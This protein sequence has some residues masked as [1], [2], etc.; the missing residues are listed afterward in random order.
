MN[1]PRIIFSFVFLVL[2][3]TQS[4]GVNCVID[5]A[6]WPIPAEEIS[7]EDVLV[8][9]NDNSPDS[10]E[11]GKYYAEKRNLGPDSIVRLATRPT[12]GLVFLE[13]R[14]M[15]NQIIKYMQEN[16]LEVGAPAAPLCEDGNA[17]YDL[18][19][20]GPYYCEAS[21]DHLRRYT[22]IRYLVTTRGVPY[23][24]KIN[25][26]PFGD[27]YTSVDNY[28]AYWLVRYFSQDVKLNFTER[29]RVFADGRGMR[30][31]DTAHD[32]ELI[33]GRIDAVEDG[34]IDVAG[35]K[36][37]A[38]KAL[39]DRIIDAENNGIYGKL[40][41]S[42][43]D[44]TAPPASWL[45]YS[46]G[47]AD[48]YGNTDSAKGDVTS[49]QYQLGI[50]G[51]NQPECTDVDYLLTDG[52][53]PQYCNVRFTN[54]GKNSAPGKSTSQVE[55]ADDALIYLGSMHE[56]A[57][58]GGSFNALLNWVKD[59]TCNA[60]LCEDFLDEVYHDACVASSTDV[61]KEINTDCVGVAE[62]F[63]GYNFRSYPVASMDLWPTGYRGT[64]EGGDLV[65]P[66]VRNESGIGHTDDY[67]LWLRNADTVGAK[68]Y[69]NI[70]Y[71][72]N[73]EATNNCRGSSDINMVTWVNFDSPYPVV[74][75]TNPQQYR[76]SFWYKSIDVN[77]GTE[78]AVQLKVL[79]SDGDG[80]DEDDWVDYG[81]ETLTE[82][83]QPANSEVI[84]NNN[85]TQIE[86]SFPL[87]SKSHKLKKLEFKIRTASY[88]DD[89]GVY[90]G[91][92]YDGEIAFDDFSIRELTDAPD[93]ELAKNPSFT[94]GHKE[95]SDGDYAATYLSRLNGVAFWGSVSHHE[96]GG[97]S[98]GNHP[99]ETLIYFLRGLP[100][101]DAVWWGEDHNSGLL[102]GD[103]IY[104]PVAVHLNNLNNNDFF[105]GNV[106]LTGSTVN[107]RDLAPGATTYEVDYCE[108]TDFYV[109]DQLASWSLSPILS[110]NGGEEDMPL[111]TWDVTNI[112]SGSYVLRLKVTSTNA[113]KT[114]S[115]Y[116]YYPIKIG[117]DVDD[118]TDGDGLK[119]SA[120]ID[121]GTNPS[122]KDTDG[123]GFSDGDEVNSYGLDPLDSNDALADTDGDGVSNYLEVLRGTSITDREESPA[124]ATW[125]VN[126]VIGNDNNTGMSETEAFQ[127]AS[128]ATLNSSL[129]AG[130]TIVLASGTHYFI[131]RDPI[132]IRLQG[133]SDR[134]AIIGSMFLPSVVWG[135]MSGITINMNTPLIFNNI[136]NFVIQNCVFN[137]GVSFDSGSIGI[138]L[139]NS[140]IK[141]S[142]AGGS[143]ILIKDSSNVSIDNNT[144]I[145]SYVGLEIDV[146]SQATLQNNIFWD[147]SYDF[148]SVYIESIA[149]VVDV[150]YTLTSYPEFA[151]QNGNISSDP[152]FDPINNDYSLEPGS[153]AKGSGLC[154]ADMG[155]EGEVVD[156]NAL[157]WMLLLL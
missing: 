58:G 56:Q 154:G 134:S 97:K 79:D 151:N 89:S 105:V 6:T 10:C 133:P 62:G 47:K 132:P 31:V 12:R 106:T 143:A 24:V 98:F 95:V 118:D 29:E 85:W 42:K 100:L 110:G 101:G 82:V 115:F 109:C 14:V 38:T 141:N 87:N 64:H 111:G 61:F 136:R 33:V 22:K 155:F 129:K 27:E 120:E 99:Q 66:E 54:T 135:E 30:T 50:F 124:F 57:S 17:D 112:P 80:V 117:G 2:F 76:I 20:D 92:F 46:R 5:P 75:E 150:S 107:G 119:D 145:D 156:C 113:G 1:F 73:F 130:D 84:G 149:D 28:L 18:D 26:S 142:V 67:S 37:S 15:M 146:S 140:V 55:T 123:D 157:T 147:N 68:C 77:D 102:Y 104:S 53:A 72:L 128:K 16:T 59:E 103:P 70:N 41:G 131:T 43:F 88:D 40:Y 108:E 116:D 4:F 36:P 65:S 34:P 45:D 25:D 52:K 93:I 60:K 148:S 91:N 74:D 39:I 63:I 51:E 13:F 125:Y 48:V 44:V 11:V 7:R 127:T 83:E 3:S 71:N 144:I 21:M 86:A 114:Q 126:P 32:G 81:T 96:S 137:D 139:R 8:I 90:K 122:V 153:P 49:W 121:Y 23:R 94:E 35:V 9:V 69:P 78:L 152:I 138:V 19:G